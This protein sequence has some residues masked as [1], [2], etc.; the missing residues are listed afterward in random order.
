[1]IVRNEKERDILLEAGRRLRTVLDAVREHIRPGVGTEDLDQMAY[2]MIIAM[3]D[4]PAF[5]NYRPAG[6]QDAFP[7]TLCVSLNQEMVHGI[8]SP[9]K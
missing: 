2:K 1:M 7:A 9:K 8:P 4:T 6:V 5:L 3:G